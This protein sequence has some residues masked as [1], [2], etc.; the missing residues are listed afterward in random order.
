M[1]DTLTIRLDVNVLSALTILAQKDMRS[2]NNVVETMILNE[3]GKLKVDFSKNFSTKK[4]L[5][6]VQDMYIDF[7]SKHIGQ[8]ETLLKNQSW[9]ST[10]EKALLE[11]QVFRDKI[12]LIKS[13]I[14]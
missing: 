3:L 8:Y 7:L 12:K 11:G 4:E 1:K 10:D 6:D 14:V 2:V 9:F 5:I 13:K